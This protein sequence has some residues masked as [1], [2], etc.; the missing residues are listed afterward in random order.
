MMWL[1]NRANLC[2]VVTAPI[3]SLVVNLTCTVILGLGFLKD[4][5]MILKAFF[6]GISLDFVRILLGFLKTFWDYS[7]S[8]FPLQFLIF[9]LLFS[10][11]LSN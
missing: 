8:V 1:I 9:P 6:S 10:A 3:F 7:V 5:F 11:A 4:S 2:P